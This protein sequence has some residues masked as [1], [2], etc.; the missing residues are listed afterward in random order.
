MMQFLCFMFVQTKS[1][2]VCSRPDLNQTTLYIQSGKSC[3]FT[4]NHETLSSRLAQVS[5]G[6]HHSMIKQSSSQQCGLAPPD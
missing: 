3:T 6:L 4:A 5:G 2:P 1:D